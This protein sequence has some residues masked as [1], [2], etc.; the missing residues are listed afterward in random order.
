M[1]AGEGEGEGRPASVLGH[2]RDLAGRAGAAGGGGEQQ[3]AGPG[4]QQQ[5]V[6]LGQGADPGEA[7]QGHEREGQAQGQAEADGIQARNPT[8]GTQNPVEREST[9][10]GLQVPPP[11]PKVWQALNSINSVTNPSDQDVN[12]FMMSLFY[13]E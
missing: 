8:K 2:E 1:V 12:N 7:G 6:G 13:W 5:G 11:K 4:Q 3:E 10:S 9:C